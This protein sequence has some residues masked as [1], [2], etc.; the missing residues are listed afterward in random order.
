[1]AKATHKS[2]KM[3]YDLDIAPGPKH[4]NPKSPGGGGGPATRYG[5]RLD[6]PEKLGKTASMNPQSP[7]RRGGPAV[8]YKHRMSNPEKPNGADPLNPPMGK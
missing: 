2:Q 1:M 4:L 7:A 6:R 5:H 8:H 3:P